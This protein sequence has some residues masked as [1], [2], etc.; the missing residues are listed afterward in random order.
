[1]RASVLIA[2]VLGAALLVVVPPDSPARASSAPAPCSAGLIAL[3]FDD[4]PAPAVTPDLLALLAAR[5]VPATFFM[6]GSRVAAHPALVRKVQRLGFVIGNHTYRHED[7]TTLSD[8]GIRS[9]LARTRRALV[10]PGSVPPRSCD[11]PTAPRTPGSGAS[12][13]RWGSPRCCGPSTPGTGSR[14][15]R[16][17]SRDGCCGHCVPTSPMSCC[18]TTASGAPRSHLRAV[19]RIITGARQRGYCFAALG[20]AGRPAP[21][22]PT[23]SA[24]APQVTEGSPGDHPGH[25]DPAPGPADVATGVVAPPHCLGQR[26]GRRGL[27]ARQPPGQVPRGRDEALG[28]RLRPGR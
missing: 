19:P 26:R 27:P 14:A 3:T 17:T 18:S 21:P 28:P 7:L 15:R 9:T 22:V 23:V 20:P 24:S 8:A 2:G 11:R 25:G 1:M 16:A 4:G 10:R 13:D 6:V 12:S 5:R